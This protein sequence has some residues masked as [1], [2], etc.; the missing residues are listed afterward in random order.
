VTCTIDNV[1]VPDLLSSYRVRSPAF[2]YT[3]PPNNNLL[4]AAEGEPCYNDPSPT[5]TPFTVVGAVAD[6]F[7]LMVAPLSLGAHTVHFTGQS[8]NILSGTYE[9]MTYNLTVTPMPALL[10]TG[11]QGTNA[12]IL[13]WPQTASGYVLET[14][15]GL[16]PANWSPAEASVQTFEGQYQVTIPMIGPVNFSG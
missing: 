4:E 6:G 7:Y 15:S 14:T 11:R 2:N 12:M 8:G 5:P 9:D 10:T 13:S 16:N 1:A 3:T